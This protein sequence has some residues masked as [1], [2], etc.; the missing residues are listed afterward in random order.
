VIFIFISKIKENIFGT[1]DKKEKMLN[2][3]KYMPN[4][5]N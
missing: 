5:G 1:E 3:G 2:F 4:S